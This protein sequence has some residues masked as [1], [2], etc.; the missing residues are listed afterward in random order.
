MSSAR[1]M[2]WASRQDAALGGAFADPVEDGKVVLVGAELAGPLA[3]DDRGVVARTT[4][5]S[6]AASRLARVRFRPAGQPSGRRTFGSSRVSSRSVWALP[7]KPPMACATSFSADLAVVAKRRVA[8]VVG[9]AGG[10]HHVRVAAQRRGPVRG[11]PAP[12]PGCGSA[13]CGRSRP[14]PGP[15]PGSWRPA[16][17][18]PRNAAPG[19]GPVR[20]RER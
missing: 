14:C 15:P 3:V 9:E 11:L 18:A 13:G 19:R 4:G 12:P 10:V 20:S 2:T 16:G 17:A 5:I 8:E 7:S 6:Q 1:S